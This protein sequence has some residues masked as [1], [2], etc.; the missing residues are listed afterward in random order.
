MIYDNIRKFIRYLLSGNVGEIW[1][2]TISLFLAMP[3]PL[4]PLQILWINLV[5]DGL[6]ALALGLELAEQD[7]MRRPPRLPNEN[8]FSRGTGQDIFLIGVLIGSASLLA[9]YNAWQAGN[10]AWQTMIFT[11]LTLSQIILSLTARFE[12]ASCFMVN[13]FTNP[14]LMGA[15][16]VTTGLQLLLIYVPWFQ[17]IF[18]TVPLSQAQLE[19]CLLLSTVGFWGLEIKKWLVRRSLER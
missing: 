7:V 19:Y 2:M 9:G 6:P 18:Q 14:T 15:A 5:S 13:P 17:D 4:L 16:F 11:T 10:L 1:T 8:L 3:I 12:Q